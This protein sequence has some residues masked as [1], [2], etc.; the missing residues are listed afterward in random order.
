MVDD[1]WRVYTIDQIKADTDRSIA[2]GPFGSRMKSDRYVPSGVPVI[3][4]N[5]ISDTG[6][7]AGDFVFVNGETADELKSS[8]VFPGDL[9]FPHRGA[10]GQVGIVPAVGP[11]R[12]VMSTSLMKL[13]CNPNLADPLFVFYFFRSEQGRHEL[14][15]HASTVGTP[16]IGQPLA[17]LKSIPIPLPPLS[18]QHAIARILG[19]LDD[20]IELNRRLNETLEA[21]AQTLF[22]SWFVDFDPVRATAEGRDVSLPSHFAKLFPRS[23]VTSPIGDIPAGW[24]TGSLLEQADLLSGGTPKTDQPDYWDGNILWASAKDVSQCTDTFLVATERTIT[25][26]GLAESATQIIPALCIVVVARGATTGRMALLGGDMAMN[27][28]CYALHSKTGT[29]FTLYCQLRHGI[30]QLVHAAHG[31]VFNTITTDTFK[32]SSVVVAP[33]SVIT[34]FEKLVKPIFDGILA[35][36]HESLTLSALRDTL[37]PKLM[38]GELRVR[39]A[40]REAK[41][42]A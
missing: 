19:A 10:I 13:S 24:A 8:N 11:G 15:K 33:E 40:K 39:D 27:Q 9:F 37:L 18:E 34:S 30:E 26:K 22:A 6:A 38:S 16:G 17:S 21:T 12:Y 2:I 41:M 4:G 28:T 14:L 35:R 31:S 3:R 42:I 5:N 32:G 36:I 20:K 25:E 1:G 7:L 29:P 23:L